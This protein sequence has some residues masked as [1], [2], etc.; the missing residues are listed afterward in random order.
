MTGCK[1]ALVGEAYGEKEELLQHGFVGPSGRE[2]ARMLNE[3]GLVDLLPHKYPSEIE[4]VHFWKKCELEKGIFIMNVYEGRPPNNNFEEMFLT[5]KKEADYSLIT[6]EYMKGKYVNSELTPHIQ[7]L[8]AKLEL[9]KPNLIIA[10]GN[11][12]CLAVLNESKITTI[13]GTLRVSPFLGIKVLPT[14]HPAAVL[15]QWPIRPITVA[16]LSK[17]VKQA[18]YAEISRTERW[19]LKRPT[20]PEIIEWFA[21]PK[22]RYSADVES[23]RALYTDKELKLMTN[24]QLKI[25][26]ESISMIGFARDRHHAMVIPLM[27]RTSPNLSYWSFND[28]VIVMKLIQKALQEPVPKV[29]QNGM[30]DIQMMLA[31]NLVPYGCTEDT[32][33]LQHSIYPEQQKSLSFLASIYAEEVAWKKA[34]G[35]GQQMKKDN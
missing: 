24:V 28:E 34:Y 1:I 19:V 15:R 13:R 21:V 4:M 25:L 35:A 3:A 22:T 17:A 32:M 30:Y 26:A 12:A 5:N 7:K 14:F 20:I 10:L 6:S 16:D 8:L 27:D 9:L 2:L 29:F 31:T 18:E 11:A 23:G 33:L